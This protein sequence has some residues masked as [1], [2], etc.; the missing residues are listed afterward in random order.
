MDELEQKYLA[1]VERIRRYPMT[2]AARARILAELEAI[3]RRERAAVA[4][5]GIGSPAQG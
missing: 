3:Y 4:R 1:L 2:E 5:R